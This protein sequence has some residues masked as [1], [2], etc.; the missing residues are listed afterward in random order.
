MICNNYSSCHN[1]EVLNEDNSAILVYC[2]HCGA[3]ERIGKDIKGTP[4]L[5]L[6]SEWFKKDVLQPDAPLYYRYAGAKGM[7]IV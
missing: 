6:Y 4:E 3:Q 2:T 1:A 7:R 5:R